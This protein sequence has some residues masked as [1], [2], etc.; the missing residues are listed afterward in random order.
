MIMKRESG[1][2]CA[3]FIGILPIFG[4]FGL[5][6][7]N[8]FLTSES[9]ILHGQTFNYIYLMALKCYISDNSEHCLG[10]YKE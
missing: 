2:I 5:L 1:R 6:F 3:N 10:E 7:E 8:L 4:S 9:M